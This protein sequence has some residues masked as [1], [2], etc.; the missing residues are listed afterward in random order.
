MR[1]MRVVRNL[2]RN[3]TTMELSS[4]VTIYDEEVGRVDCPLSL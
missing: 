2:D 3:P 4:Y 1:R